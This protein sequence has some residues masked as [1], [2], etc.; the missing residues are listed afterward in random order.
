MQV[1]SG[2]RKYASSDCCWKLCV[3][4]NG[5]RPTRSDRTTSLNML[6]RKD[7]APNEL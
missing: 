1:R 7:A 6:L 5:S 4:M 2:L 3:R